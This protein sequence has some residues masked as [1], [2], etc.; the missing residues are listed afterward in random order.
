MTHQPPAAMWLRSFSVDL[1]P[2]SWPASLT[3]AERAVARG[4]IR[5]ESCREIARDRSASPSTVAVQIASVL[6]KCG[7]NSKH[8]L[9]SVLAGG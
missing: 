8:E 6:A 3:D 9:V 2:R 1:E 4:L 5:G 7:C